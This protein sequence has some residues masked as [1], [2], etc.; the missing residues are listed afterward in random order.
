MRQLGMSYWS[1]WWPVVVSALLLIILILVAMLVINQSMH[2]ASTQGHVLSI[3][4]QNV[5]TFGIPPAGE[6]ISQQQ[7]DKIGWI[8][9]G[10]TQNDAV[11]AQHA[12][13]VFVQ[14]EMSY[15]YRDIGTPT[16]HAGTLIAVMPLLTLG[17]RTRFQQNDVRMTNNALYDA[18]SSDQIIRQAMNIQA[19][20]L[21]FHVVSVQGQPHQFVWFTVSF[22]R[23]QSYVDHASGKRIE[24]NEIDSTLEQ[25][26]VYQMMVVLMRV[27]P[28]KQGLEAQSGWRVNAYDLDATT[29]L[30]IETAPTL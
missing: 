26:R 17:A 22:N 14:R 24:G 19:K 4:S 29:P 13:T 6:G 27:P 20:L 2:S 16:H 10:L 3:V 12:A 23:F 28:D 9:A 15:D 7:L 1:K 11:A 21:Q 25:P 30:A 5:P 8:K 18:I